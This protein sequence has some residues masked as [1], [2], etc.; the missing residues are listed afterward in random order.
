MSGKEVDENRIRLISSFIIEESHLRMEQY[1]TQIFHSQ[2]LRAASSILIV[3]RLEKTKLECTLHVK[4]RS[5][6][7]VWRITTERSLRM[8]TMTMRH[9][10][11]ISRIVKGLP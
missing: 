3:L 9:S 8:T 2:T 11:H 4:Q 6:I 7:Q 1:D 5:S 10:Q